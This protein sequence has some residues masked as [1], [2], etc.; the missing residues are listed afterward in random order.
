MG[1]VR[2]VPTFTSAS[3]PGS[4]WAWVAVWADNVIE[5]V[6]VRWAFRSL[7]LHESPVSALGLTSHSG[8][9]MRNG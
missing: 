2:Q 9:D 4:A 7:C 1:P 8:S 6:G 3:N 5:G